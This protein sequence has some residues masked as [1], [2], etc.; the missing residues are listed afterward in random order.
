MKN[1]THVLIIIIFTGICCVLARADDPAEPQFSAHV[2]PLLKTYCVTCHG[3]AKPKSDFAID[4]L[5]PSFATSSQE[6]KG[7]LDRLSEGSMPPK[8]KPRPSDSERA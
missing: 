8:G 3:G 6:W 1:L 5:A 4:T 7:I 2:A